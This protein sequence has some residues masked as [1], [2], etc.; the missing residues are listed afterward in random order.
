M[1]PKNK[2]DW[3]TNYRVI[4]GTTACAILGHSKWKT[5]LEVY[6]DLTQDRTKFKDTSNEATLRGKA[7]EPHLRAMF[8]INFPQYKVLSPRG[9]EMFVRNDKPYMTA[10]LDGRLIHKITKAKLVLEIK[11]HDIRNKKDEEEWDNTIPIY[12]FDQIM[13]YL[14]VMTDFQGAELEAHLN[15]Y[16]YYHEDGKKL[17]RTEIRYYYYDRRDKEVSDY[18]NYIENECTR[19]YEENVKK[20]I[21]PQV[22]IEF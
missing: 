22:K 4:G 7:L 14:A 17:L 21:P 6:N 11:T 19:F 2:E 20:G 12:Y 1:R 3:L 10:T 13:R 9:Y 5:K 8:G 16:D 15:F 18:I